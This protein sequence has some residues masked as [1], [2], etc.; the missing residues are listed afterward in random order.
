MTRSLLGHISSIDIFSRFTF[1]G[2]WLL[3]KRNWEMWWRYSCRIEQNHS[4]DEDDEERG[5]SCYP[6]LSFVEC[7]P[8]NLYNIYWC[9]RWSKSTRQSDSQSV[10]Q[11]AANINGDGDGDGDDD[12]NNNSNNNSER[13]NNNALN[14]ALGQSS[15]FIESI[16]MFI[17]VQIDT[18][19]L[20]DI[21]R[22][23]GE[24]F[25]LS[26][27]EYRF[28]VSEHT[29]VRVRA[30]STAM[31]ATDKEV[32]LHIP[33]YSLGHSGVS[34]SLPLS[35]S[36]I[37]KNAWYSSSAD[38]QASLQG[39]FL[40]LCILLLCLL[41]INQFKVRRL[42]IDQKTREKEIANLCKHFC[43]SLEEEEEEEEEDVH[44]KA[45]HSKAW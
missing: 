31:R 36:F 1:L 8:H 27:V 29:D 35:F 38:D 11:L 15:I 44:G 32:F 13:R 3:T 17:S 42:S 28:Q 7:V 24:R 18:R 12:D 22:T 2:T 19:T 10:N 40:C 5:R 30:H 20:S 6:S 21:L 37:E 33:H 41:E 34:L 14:D 23:T 26:Q 4:I 9:Q 45:Q 25:V 43:L 16:R 39:N